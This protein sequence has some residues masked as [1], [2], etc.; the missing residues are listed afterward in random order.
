MDNLP[1]LKLRE[2]LATYGRSL[3]DEPK[4]CEGLLRD[5]CGEHKLEINLLMDAVRE[6]VPADLLAASTGVSATMMLTRLRTRMQDE[7]G[8][9]EAA[10]R[11]AVYS[12]AF[13]LGIAMPNADSDEGRKSTADLNSKPKAARPSSRVTKSKP[14]QPSHAII[15]RRADN[16]PAVS[17]KAPVTPVVAP[18]MKPLTSS[19]TAPAPSGDS[20]VLW[21]IIK[22]PFIFVGSIVALF[23][24][25][26]AVV[27]AF[28]VVFKVIGID[29]NRLG[30]AAKGI[31]GL[32][33]LAIIALVLGLLPWPSRKGK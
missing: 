27:G 4:R 18:T 29:Y 32:V 24:V 16:A 31:L 23:A 26:I 8:L 1:R 14:T 15:D 6:R 5:L 22:V 33:M 2:L 28:V 7:L 9:S 3:C 20:S 11:W 19:G 17:A 13:A 12:W 25:S 21:E 10:A 30:E